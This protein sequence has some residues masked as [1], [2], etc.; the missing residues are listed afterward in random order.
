MGNFWDLAGPVRPKPSVLRA[1]CS[2]GHRPAADGAAHGPAGRCRWPPRGPWWTCWP[3]TGHAQLARH[4][5]RGPP[6]GRW[7]GSRRLRTRVSQCPEAWGLPAHPPGPGAWG[8]GPLGA[9]WAEQ[10]RILPSCGLWARS[11]GRLQI[12]SLLRRPWF[13]STIVSGVRASEAPQP[14]PGFAEGPVGLEIKPG[15]VGAGVWL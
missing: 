5:G 13:F 11:Q 9:V 1:G 6:G 4:S 10:A 15:E 3:A 2:P 12:T 7:S 14:F 8:A